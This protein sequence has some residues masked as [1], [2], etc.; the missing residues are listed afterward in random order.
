MDILVVTVAWSCVWVA[1]TLVVAALRGPFDVRAPGEAAWTKG[2]GFLAGAFIATLWMRVL[3]ALGVPFAETWSCYV[4]GEVHC[5]RCG[6]CVERRE[7]FD[8]AGVPDPTAYD[9]VTA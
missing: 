9:E 2:S 1:G 5:G 6:T 8:L 4:G 7:A 3:S